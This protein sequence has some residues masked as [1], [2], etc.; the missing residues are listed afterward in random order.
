MIVRFL[1]PGV[2]SISIKGNRDFLNRTEQLRND[3]KDDGSFDYEEG[4]IEANNVAGLL[5]IKTRRENKEKLSEGI[6]KVVDDDPITIER[7]FSPSALTR[8][9]GIQY[10]LNSDS[11]VEDLRRTIYRFHDA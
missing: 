6:I 10:S 2:T 8:I 1:P 9:I 3:L 5:L 4:T 7:E 11:L